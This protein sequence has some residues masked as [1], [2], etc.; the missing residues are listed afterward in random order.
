[1]LYVV[2]RCLRLALAL[3]LALPCLAVPV[4]V[5][6][7]ASP[8]HMDDGTPLGLGRR[9]TTR[10]PGGKG[11]Q[12]GDTCRCYNSELGDPAPVVLVVTL[13]A[14]LVK[15]CPSTITYSSTRR[16]GLCWAVQ[17]SATRSGGVASRVGY[18]T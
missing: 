8:S 10:R 17:K 18:L 4:S 3:A 14:P 11:L 15:H 9:E 5:L 13:C 16:A 2:R 1:M 7:S 12:G 6:D